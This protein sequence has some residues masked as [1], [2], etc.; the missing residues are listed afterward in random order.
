MLDR[1]EGCRGVSRVSRVSRMSR[2]SSRCRVLSRGFASKV[3]RCPRWQDAVAAHQQNLGSSCK[4]VSSLIVA[5]SQLH[6][7]DV[8]QPE[9]NQYT[10]CGHLRTSSAGS[11][12]HCAPRCCAGAAPQQRRRCS[13][14]APAAPPAHKAQLTTALM[15]QGWCHE[16]VDIATAQGAVQQ[17]RATVPHRSSVAAAAASPLQPSV[18][19]AQ[20]AMDHRSALMAQAHWCEDSL[21]LYK[22]L[23]ST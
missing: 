1:V 9:H 19:S 2:V 17:L 22:V 21:P 7:V 13:S 5:A 12:C 6:P 11:H 18:A 14:V 20:S 16:S 15:A 3:S 23:C 4:A 8:A 10:L